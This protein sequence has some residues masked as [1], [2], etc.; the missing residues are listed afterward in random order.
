M[1]VILNEDVKGLG[2]KGEL[3]STSDGYARNFLFPRKLATE[4]N[5]QAMTEFKNRE[6]SKQHK[7]DVDVAN[8]KANAEK[9]SDKVI[10]LTAKAGANGKLFGSVTS[11]EIAEKIKS[12]FG[13][14]VDK[15]KIIVDDIKNFGTYEAEVKLYQGISAKLKVQVGEE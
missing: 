5:A 13:I 4:A 3:V 6:S 2:K 12:E 10:R 14:D 11:K 15:R 1:K 7:I 8:A 9:I